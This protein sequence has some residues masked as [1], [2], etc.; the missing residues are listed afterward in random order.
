MGQVYRVMDLKTG[1]VVAL[2][3]VMVVD[4][5]REARMG[6]GGHK[7]VPPEEDHRALAREFKLL[8][9]LRHPHIVDVIDYDFDESGQPYYTMAY[10]AD[11]LPIIEYCQDRTLECKIDLLVHMFEALAYL[12]EHN[13][14]HRDLKPD[15]VL[16]MNGQVKLLDF[17]LSTAD[18]THGYALQGT[19]A[20][21][22][23]ELLKGHPPSQATDLYAAGVV[24]YELLAGHHPY[25]VR[26][27]NQ[28]MLSVLH[29]EADV[30]ALPVDPNLQALVGKL[31]ANDAQARPQN[32]S[33]VVEELA[34][35]D[36]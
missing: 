24:A 3:R 8:A 32:A 35:I 12:H 20:Y 31:L 23:P 30:A 4:A 28:L 36:Y 9:D 33:G 18:T 6:E 11:A 10:L 19:A 5:L 1:R 15:N 7:V 16:V 22:A 21:M 17:G 26:N 29:E 13:V 14:L 34:K 25:D 27:L 2:K